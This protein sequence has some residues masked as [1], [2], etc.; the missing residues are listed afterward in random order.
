[1]SGHARLVDAHQGHDVVDRPFVVQHLHDAPPGGIGE[2]LED[3][4]LHGHIYT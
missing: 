4:E 1:M 3:V 2:G